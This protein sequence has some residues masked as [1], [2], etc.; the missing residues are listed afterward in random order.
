MQAMQFAVLIRA[1]SQCQQKFVGLT[2]CRCNVRFSGHSSKH[3]T[4]N[5]RLCDLSRTCD[6]NCYSDR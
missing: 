6:R 2:S 4:E 5:R 3:K 1:L